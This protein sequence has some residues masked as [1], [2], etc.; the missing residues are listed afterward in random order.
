MTWT[1]Q[2]SASLDIVWVLSHLSH[3]LE[4]VDYIVF[5]G[6]PGQTGETAFRFTSAPVISTPSSVSSDFINGTL[7]I[8]YSFL[9]GSQFITIQ[10]NQSMVVAI[11]L[12][13]VTAN[14]WHAPVISGEGDFGQF[15]SIGTNKSIL[16]AG[17]YVVR[18]AEITGN[19]VAL[20]NLNG[21]TTVEFLA[22]SNVNSL[23]WNGVPASLSNTQCGF[24]SSQLDGA[25]GI[26]LPTLSNWK[27]LGR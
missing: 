5:Y 14:T 27:V 12:D 4:E 9:S 22:P 25:S 19:M 24:F 10:N 17:P 26:T 11:V 8:S 20:A 6:P 18:T 7:T 1:T 16:V 15:F 23:T 21:T 2:V 13:K 3:S